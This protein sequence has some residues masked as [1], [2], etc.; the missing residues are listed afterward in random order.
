MQCNVCSVE[1]KGITPKKSVNAREESREVLTIILDFVV[2][3][4]SQ[5]QKNLNICETFLKSI[6]VKDFK[7]A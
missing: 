5:I 1:A 4:Q 7:M 3:D 2:Q 6:S